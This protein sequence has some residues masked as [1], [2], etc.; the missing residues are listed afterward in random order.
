[1]LV[2]SHP[3]PRVSLRFEHEK[4]EV[5]ETNINNFRVVSKTC[6]ALVICID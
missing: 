2:N 3:R 5:P 1:M 6:Y 4:E